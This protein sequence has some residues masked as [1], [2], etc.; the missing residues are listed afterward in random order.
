MIGNQ[1]QVTNTKP[2]NSA[3]KY[4]KLILTLTRKKTQNPYHLIKY[5]SNITKIKKINK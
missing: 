1:L 3:P 5:K 2:I 4:Y